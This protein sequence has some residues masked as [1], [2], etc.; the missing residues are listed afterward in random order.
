MPTIP[1]DLVTI[2]TASALSQIHEITIRRW[3]A[4]RQIRYFGRKGYYR[5]S[6]A[7]LM[8]EVE[9]LA[10]APA[11]SKA[12]GKRKAKRIR[13]PQPKRRTS[14]SSPKTATL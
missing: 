10:Q 2:A 9:A 14:A 7:D 6:M 11:Q 8:P 13:P 4:K 5:I 1:T 12:P 3:M